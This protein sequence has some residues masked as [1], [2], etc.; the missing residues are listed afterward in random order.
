MQIL[1][2]TANLGEIEK[3]VD[4]YPLDGVTTNPTII[5]GEGRIDFYAHLHRIRELIGPDRMLHVQVLATNA[6]GMIND[7]HR[8]LDKID[9]Q[10]YVKIPTT[11]QGL[12]AMRHLKAQGVHVT[13]TAIYSKIQGMLA[14]ATGADYIAPY[15]NRMES[16]DVDA[17]ATVTFLANFAKRAGNGTRVMPAS[18]KNVAQVC[19]AIDAGAHAVTVQPKLLRAALFA[20]DVVSAVQAFSDDWFATFGTNELP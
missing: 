17:A 12:K 1:F 4:V 8:L 9:D 10:V 5:K 20:P 19:A 6:T 13:G 18:F 7:A 3:A 14:I 2:D 11:E 15:Y 16:I